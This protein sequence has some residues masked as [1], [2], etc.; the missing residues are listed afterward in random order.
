MTVESGVSVRELVE[1]FADHLADDAGTS[2]RTA[3]FYR[4]DLRE[5]ARF[6]E[7][8]GVVEIWD[9]GVGRVMEFRNHL[10]GARRKRFTVYR[11]DAAVRRF[12]DWVRTGT[13]VGLEFDPI[14]PMH[15][16]LD[17]QIT[18]LDDEDAERLLSFPADT[19]TAARDAAVIVLML[20]TGATVSEARALLRDDVDLDAGQVRLGGPGSHLNARTRR[21]SRAAAEILRRYLSLRS[22]DTPELFVG[23]AARPISTS[24]TLQNALWKRCDQVG[25]PRISPMVLR[26][27]F[28]VRLLRRGATLN[29]LK[30]AMGVRDTT[31]IGVYKKFV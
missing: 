21:I 8:R 19:L 14:E 26:H 20:E 23:R 25:L 10:L 4:S 13:D 22:D 5:F 28:A 7:E 12:L 17:Q 18:F 30:E 9:V 24:K 29:E 3:E 1:K 27:T 15:Q 31:N 16:P 6:L 2:P 11:K